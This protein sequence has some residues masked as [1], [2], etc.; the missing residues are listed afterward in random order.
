MTGL[1]P[2]IV[3]L[4][5][6]LLVAIRFAQRFVRRT[7]AQRDRAAR[8]LFLATCAQA[9]HFAEEAATG[10]ADHF[11]RMFGQPPMPWSVFITFNLACVAVWAISVAG[12]RRGWF[13]ATSAAWFL[14]VA[15]A[16][17]G[18]AHPLFAIAAGGYFPGLYTS[19]LIG[20]AGAYL[21]WTLSHQGEPGASRAGS[22]ASRDESRPGRLR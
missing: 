2:S 16:L 1:L 5:A 9:A 19:P 4:G 10:F 17:N 3:A 13:W 8:A 20:A 14:A 6:A 11:P 21:W 7:S 22:T 12:L 15:G 18:L